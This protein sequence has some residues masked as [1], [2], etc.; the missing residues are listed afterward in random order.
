MFKL[1]RI[2]DLQL[3]DEPIAQRETTE[4]QQQNWWETENQVKTT[5]RF[6]KSVRSRLIDEWGADCL[7]YDEG[8]NIVITFTRLDSP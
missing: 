1:S 3:N 6:D 4:Y 7:Q 8:S 2:A 5:M